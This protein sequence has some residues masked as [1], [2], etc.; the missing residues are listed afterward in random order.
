ML[1]KTKAVLMSIA[2]IGGLFSVMPVWAEYIPENP[3][4]RLD[5]IANYGE[6]LKQRLGE[7][8]KFLSSGGQFIVNLGEQLDKLKPV[9][10]RYIKLNQRDYL[11]NELAPV[12]VNNKNVSSDFLSRMAGSTQ[13]ETSVA[14]CG[15]NAVCGFNDSGSLLVTNLGPSPSPSGSLS[16]NGYSVSTDKGATFKDKGVF[17]ADPLPPGVKFRDLLGDPVLKCKNSTTFYYASLALD[18][19]DI[20][21]SPVP[22]VIVEYSGISVSKSTNGGNTFG[23]AVM[24]A[25]KTASNHFLDKPW[26]AVDPSNNNVY[27]AYSDF[28]DSV[29]S[30]RVAI[31][32]VR[33]TDGGATWSATPFVI[34]EAL[35]DGNSNT[36]DPFVQ[37]S[38]VA[39]GPNGEVYVAWETY[40]ADELTRSIKVRKSTN[41]GVSF[42]PAKVI[43]KVT[44]IGVGDVLQGLFR[45]GPDLQ[46]LAVDNS[47]SSTK[48]NVYCTWHDGRNK[49][50]SDP[51]GI[52]DKYRFA[53]ILFSRST[54]GGNT[55]SAPVRVNTDAITKKVDQFMPAL[56]VDKNGTVGVLYYDRRM[57][58]R[59][60]LIDVYYAKSTNAGVK[61]TDSRITTKNFAPIHFNDAVVNPIYM[62]DYVSLASDVSN[63][64]PGFVGAWEEN[65]K[66]DQNVSADQIGQP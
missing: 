66:G 53:D 58:S 65:S 38:Q 1:R 42:L 35:G 39:V 27:V 20:K 64:T 12:A 61:W 31:E 34:E 15:N 32:F 63:T 30:G 47:S 51:F 14:W 29:A 57:D 48:G 21:V 3:E 23:G 13:S 22:A 55:W 43:S 28:D 2:C 54:D 11:E 33:S 9:L 26:M 40:S 18:S 62:G 60:F 10:G 25:S 5:G 41:G 44:Y 49:S 7:K 17:V 36:S 4:A 16:F 45:S 50:Q 46:G 24:A 19:K 52:E 56:A 6:H 59:N 37:G 8:T